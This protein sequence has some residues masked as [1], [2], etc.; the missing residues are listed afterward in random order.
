MRVIKRIAVCLIL[1]VVIISNVI[2]V[3]AGRITTVIPYLLGDVDGDG[4]VSIIDATC[5]QRHL[6]ELPVLSYNESAADTD[7]D[8]SVTIID[9]TCIQQWLASLP[10][11]D[12]IGEPIE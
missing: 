6:A 9:A 11:P 4:S 12:G 10:C 7:G 3:G 1:F 5:I 2:S 8:G